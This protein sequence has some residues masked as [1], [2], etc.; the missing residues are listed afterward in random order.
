MW[1]LFSPSYSPALLKGILTCIFALWISFIPWERCFTFLSNMASTHKTFQRH[2]HFFLI[3]FVLSRFSCLCLFPIFRNVSSFNMSSEE[4]NAEVKV[5]G[6]SCAF[7]DSSPSLSVSHVKCGLQWLQW[8][9]WLQSLQSLQSLHTH[10]PQS[11]HC[12]QSSVH[13]PLQWSVPHSLSTVQ[14]LGELTELGVQSCLEASGAV[15]F[16]VW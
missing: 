15:S 6:R 8:L 2:Y 11:M 13:W 9:Q 12:P 14:K 7:C 4:V 16:S 1:V 3:I 10:S 5:F